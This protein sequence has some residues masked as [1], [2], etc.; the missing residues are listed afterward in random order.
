MMAERFK[1]SLRQKNGESNGHIDEVYRVF[2]ECTNFNY[3]QRDALMSSKEILK[4]R[5]IISIQVVVLF[6]LSC[7]IGKAPPNQVNWSNQPVTHISIHD[8]M[9]KI[10]SKSPITLLD[11]R[12]E[13]D[14]ESTGHLNG[15]INIP[16]W[17]FMDRFDELESV[18]ENELIVY[19][20]LGKMSRYAS[21]VLEYNGFTNVLNLQGG[22]A[23]WKEA[24]GD[25]LVVQ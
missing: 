5:P 15:A 8:V 10:K 16:F 24:Y 4:I 23:A 1:I 22:L 3:V 20:N 19:C 25:S 2:I 6:L 17:D 21:A 11:V 13:E 7:R 14:F 18:G 9:E 12:A